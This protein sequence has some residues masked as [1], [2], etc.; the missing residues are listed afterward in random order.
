MWAPAGLGRDGISPVCCAAAG[1]A[2]QAPAPAC[3]YNTHG[4]ILPT[5]TTTTTTITITTTIINTNN[6]INPLEPLYL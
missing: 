4:V 5:T 6:K 1:G 2:G 3:T